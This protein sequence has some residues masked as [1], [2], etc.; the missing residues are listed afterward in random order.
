MIF[1]IL[2]T[3]Y[4]KLKKIHNI[5][6]SKDFNH[7]RQLEKDHVVDDTLMQL[8]YIIILINNNNYY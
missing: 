1:M 8:V 4:K 3:L 2:F 6:K 7:L 5:V